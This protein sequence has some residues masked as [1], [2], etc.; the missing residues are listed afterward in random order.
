MVAKVTISLETKQFA[1]VMPPFHIRFAP[2]GGPFRLG[3]V[4]EKSVTLASMN[5][6]AELQGNLVM[7]SPPDLIPREIKACFE[8]ASKGNPEVE[9]RRIG[10][11]YYFDLLRYVKFVGFSSYLENKD[12]G[13]MGALQLFWD[14]EPVP[15]IQALCFSDRP[16][17]GGGILVSTTI[18][19]RGFSQPEFIATLMAYQL[20]AIKLISM[21]RELMLDR[22]K[23]TM[24]IQFYAL[25]YQYNFILSL[26]NNLAINE[27]EKVSATSP[28][29]HQMEAILIQGYQAMKMIY[30]RMPDWGKVSL[31]FFSPFEPFTTPPGNFFAAG[32][33]TPELFGK[34]DWKDTIN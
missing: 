28:L 13:I 15:E 1:L 33:I 2:K 34:R 18:P 9:F 14:T 19:T 12:V 22:N 3:H 24:A 7:V 6:Q 21:R 10:P 8:N 29:R 32:A 4:R 27:P 26:L 30:G 31:K 11:G 20:G 5:K 25:A 16:T 23:E 17:E